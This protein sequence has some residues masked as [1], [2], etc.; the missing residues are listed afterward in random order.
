MNQRTGIL[1]SIMSSVMIAQPISTQANDAEVFAPGYITETVIDGNALSGVNGA[2]GVNV[3]A[4][5]ANLQANSAAIT[6]SPGGTARTTITSLQ[7]TAL[8]QNNAPDIS[9][10]GIRDGAFSNSSG[11]LS[12]NQVSGASNAQANGFSFGIGIE[13]ITDADL[14]QTITGYAND[15]TI[16]GADKPG[17]RIADIEATAFENSRGIVQVNQ[18][19]GSG[20]ATKNNFALRISTGAK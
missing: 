12:I 4:G 16:S 3:A 15:S 13:V 11:I 14:A 2:V 17:V 7:R 18:T 19:A 9:V 10:A 8:G 6:I 1:L 5:D 20:N